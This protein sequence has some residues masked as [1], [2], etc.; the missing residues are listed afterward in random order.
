M[1]ESNNSN[2]IQVTSIADIVKMAKGEIVELPGFKSDQK[3]YFRLVRPSML[4]L[5]KTGQIPNS[6]LSRAADLF[7]K[8]SRS[9]NNDDGDVLA[10][11][12]DVLNSI[13]RAAMVEPTMDQLTSNGVSLT[14]EQLMAIFN[15]TQNGVNSLSQFREQPAGNAPTLSLA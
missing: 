8:G 2:N 12:Y 9:F 14:D 11:S 10:E 5:A 15:Y 13:A 7:S 3:V 6:L 1:Y 4:M